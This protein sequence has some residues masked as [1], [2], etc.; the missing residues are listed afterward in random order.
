MAPLDVESIYF[1]IA[2]IRKNLKELKKLSQ[3]PFKKYQSN[4][5]NTATAERLIHVTI[6]AMLDIGSHIVATEALGEPLEYREV[7]I[8]LTQNGILPKD[9]EKNFLDLAGLRNR[10]VHLYDEID[11][12]LLHK[13][14]RTEL[15][16]MEVFIKAIL[17]YLEK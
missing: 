1:R 8:L 16:D 11:H 3:Y 2:R 14:L 15:D 12:K 10:I 17:K 4:I 6:E 5:L 13:A 9:K 7:F